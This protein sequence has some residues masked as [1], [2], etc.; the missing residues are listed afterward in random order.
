MVSKIFHDY[1]MVKGLLNK[2]H[3]MV[4]EESGTYHGKGKDHFPD[5]EF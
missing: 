2:T 3:I 5:S 1:G 4:R